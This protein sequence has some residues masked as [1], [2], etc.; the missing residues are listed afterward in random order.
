MKTS[1]SY[2]HD[3]NA[4]AVLTL[5][6]VNIE[7]M[8]RLLPASPCSLLVEKFSSSDPFV[9]GFGVVTGRPGNGHDWAACW[10]TRSQDVPILRGVL[11]NILNYE[12]PGRPFKTITY[13]E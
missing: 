5:N 2:A 1:Y 9:R 4:V 13:F 8:K 11:D 6:G 3:N 12:V 10:I 7:A